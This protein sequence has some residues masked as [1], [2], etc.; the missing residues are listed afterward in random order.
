MLD[1]QC[2]Q[3]LFGTGCF[4]II[5]FYTECLVFEGRLTLPELNSYKCTCFRCESTKMGSHRARQEGRASS[6]FSEVIKGIQ[7][8]EMTQLSP[9]GLRL[10]MPGTVGTIK[11]RWWQ[12][13]K[14]QIGRV[15]TNTAYLVQLV[16][17]P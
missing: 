17:V 1:E 3:G 5:L 15:P 6:A 13:C 8:V 7:W 11:L 4:W 14:K 9:R 12:K 10:H 16:S 2:A